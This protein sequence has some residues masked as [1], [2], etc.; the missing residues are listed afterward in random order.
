VFTIFSYQNKCPHKLITASLAVSRQILHSKFAFVWLCSSVGL[1]EAVGPPPFDDDGPSLVLS[2]AIFFPVAS[3]WW[4]GRRHWALLYIAKD[5]FSSE[6]K[7][8][9]YLLNI[10]IWY[11]WFI[12][13]PLTALFFFL[14]RIFIVFLFE[15]TLFYLTPVMFFQISHWFFLKEQKM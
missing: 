13:C 6:I 8:F 3:F 7:W 12:T 4:A 14:F 15:N 11:L 5:L 1:P 2:V 10:W 9:L